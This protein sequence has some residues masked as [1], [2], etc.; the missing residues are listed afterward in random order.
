ETSDIEIGRLTLDLMSIASPATATHT[1]DETL[2]SGMPATVEHDQSIVNDETRL[3]GELGLTSW[4]AGGL[5]LPFRVFDTHIRY[6]DPATGRCGSAASLYPRAPAR[7]SRSAARC[8]IRSSSATWASRTST[9]SSE[10]ARSSRS[11]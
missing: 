2:T 10:P 1:A 3:V 5:V 11:S 7:R 9:R 6:L 8:R 4:L